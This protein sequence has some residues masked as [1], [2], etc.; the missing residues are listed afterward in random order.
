MVRAA[1][2]V[3]DATVSELL[4]YALEYDENLDSTHLSL[5]L[6]PVTGITNNLDNITERGVCMIRGHL[7]GAWSFESAL[8][9]AFL[10]MMDTLCQIKSWNDPQAAIDE[11]Y[12]VRLLPP[13]PKV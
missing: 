2:S 7:V 12:D 1:L 11:V 10:E 13:S 6:E 8:E 3:Y 4:Q 5:K 9:T